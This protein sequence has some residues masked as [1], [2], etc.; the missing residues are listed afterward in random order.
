MTANQVTSTQLKEEIPN[1]PASVEAYADCLM[2]DLFE[3]VERV[4][5][6]GTKLSDDSVPPEFIALKPIKIPQIVLPPMV[7]PEPQIDETDGAHLRNAKADD[8]S[9]TIDRLLLG[10][11]FASLLV[12]LSL[13]L[14]TRGGFSR[15]F[16]PAPVAQPSETAL[17]AKAQAD[18]KFADY[19]ERSLNMIQQKPTADAPVAL[20][21]FPGN[22]PVSNN[23]PTLPV[24]GTPAGADT[25]ALI[26]AIN[27]V[28]EVVQDAS[29]Q[30]A[31]LSNQ[32]LRTLQQQGQ[33]PP[34]TTPVPG[35]QTSGS[36][37]QSAANSPAQTSTNKPSAPSDSAENTS[38]RAA[39]IPDVPAPTTAEESAPEVAATTTAK[40]E[41]VHT[42]V[43]VLD[44]G[45]RSAALFEVD[46]V[47]RRIYIGE[48]I[49]ASGWTL[50]EVV[51]QEAVI[52]RNGEVRTIFTG[53]QF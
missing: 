3:D 14:A 22:P 24:P 38:P 53:Q 28:A 36:G 41:T 40:A 44:L 13:W 46:G 1:Q 8:A 31:A 4:L 16:A 26:A 35:G 43:G 2:D 15:L 18:S 25:S 47:A 50:V 51:G 7:H 10:A 23:L 12:T 45:D 33:Q 39:V 6:G 20:P 34:S 19:V 48:S 42:L 11:A 17:S 5:D 29:D 21:V 30:T 27:R 9:Q 32:V 52:R 37:T 49:A